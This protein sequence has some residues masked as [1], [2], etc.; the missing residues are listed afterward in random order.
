MTEFMG[1][2]V[3]LFLVLMIMLVLIGFGGVSVYYQYTFKNLNQ[4]FDNVSID[5]GLCQQNLSVTTD[6]FMTAVKSLNST[7]TDIR[8]YD[9]LYE[10]KAA[11]L[12]QKKTELSNTQ[13][14]LT[15]VTVQ[16]EVYKAQIDQAYTQIIGLNRTI[17]T[18][19]GQISGLNVQIN[20]LDNRVTC[21]RNT[22]DANEITQCLD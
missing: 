6:A 18:L 16:K 13:A 15:R 20:R 9:T 21:L 19:Y 7:E 22:P 11:E 1:K 3:N 17:T 14:E 4:K 5:L 8:K 10:Q 12:E 2:R